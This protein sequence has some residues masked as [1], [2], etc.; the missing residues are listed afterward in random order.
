M[1]RIEEIVEKVGRSHPEAD[2]DL[3]RRAY[4]F[5]AR[6]HKGQ[7]RASGE[8]Y[9][10]HPLEVAN[11]L[12]DMRLDEVSV[13]TGLL[14][15]VVEDTLAEPETIREYF[16]EDVSHLVEGLTKIAQISSQS[17][18]VQQAENVRKMLLAMVDD[19][20]VVL[21]KLADRLHNMRTL[22]YLKPEK[23]QRIAQETIDIYA[24]IA[25]RLGMGKVRGELEDLSFR[26]LHPEDYRSLTAQLEQRRAGHEAFLAAAT[27]KIEEQLKESDVPY[28]RVEGRVKRLYSIFKKLRR[29]KI[30]LDQVYDLVAARVVTPD[31]VRYCYAALGV[32]HNTWKPVPGRFKDWI[33][34]PRDNLYQSLHTSV[35]GPEGQPFEIQIRTEEMHRI[36]EEGVAAHWKYKEGRRGAHDDD[37]AFQWL[38]SLI[39]WTQEVKDSRD[40][41]ESLKLDLYPKDVY[42]FTP[43]GK[44]IQLPRG[45]TPVDFA[46]A[47]HTE[48][49]NTCTGARINGRMAALRTPIQN[50]DVVEIIRTQGATPSR[51]WLN[52]V[53]TSKARS[54]VRHWVSEQQRAESIE[55]GRKMFEREAS[56]FHLSPKKLLNDSDG[57]M[58]RVAGEYGYGRA[59]DLLAA[60][61]YGKLVPRSVIAKYLGPEKFDEQAQK[62]DG[63]KPSRLRDGVEAVKRMIRL[64]D[65]SIVVRGVDDLLVNRARCCNPVHGEAIV[66]YVTRGK[67]VAVHARRCK[68][69]EQLMINPERIVEV[70]WAGKPDSVAYAVKLL[71]VTENRNGML[72]GITAAISDMKTGIRD[73]RATVAPDNRG[74]V[75]VTVE[76]FDVKHLD[77]VMRSVRNVPGVLD[78][79]R[80]NGAA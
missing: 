69:V 63:Q 8:P 77:K 5:S 72:A 65:D 3:L 52:F 39:E 17:K 15:D 75:E 71:A 57:G 61:G 49:G 2:L 59:D 46:Y 51:D 21:V 50:G 4:F 76:V 33:G 1:I 64:G 73:A 74:R 26:H 53:V 6:A 40:F 9:L 14:H 29:Q 80:M 34:T 10:V 56:R 36:A 47:I 22:H 54:R 55:I 41:L 13:A 62:L 48:V 28:V 16:G 18:E 11:I 20:R 25:H 37:E 32:I 45:A 24:P 23:R 30:E 44:I 31:D 58:K 7:T 38:R 19:V 79:E 70:E 27:S 68:N 66:G 78:V 60:I 35:I 67:G 42:A 12:A 43:M